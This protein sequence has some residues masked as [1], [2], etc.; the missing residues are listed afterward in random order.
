MAALCPAPNHNSAVTR[1]DTQNSYLPDRAVHPLAP[2][3]QFLDDQ[4]RSYTHA[5]SCTCVQSAPSR[6]LCFLAA[7]TYTNTRRLTIAPGRSWSRDRTAKTRLLSA[8]L[9]L[10]LHCHQCITLAGCAQLRSCHACHS[11]A[12]P[13]ARAKKLLVRG[14]LP[15]VAA[16]RRGL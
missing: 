13:P 10:M 16:S 12:V 4:F 8:W 9:A 3:M 11:G 7:K 2:P 1:L 6:P 15:D 14:C 5:G